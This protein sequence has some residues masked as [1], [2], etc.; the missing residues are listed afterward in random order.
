MRRMYNP[1]GDAVGL[2]SAH[3]S[4][5]G[6]CRSAW[7]TILLLLSSLAA[8][9]GTLYERRRDG[10]V[11][12]RDIDPNLSVSEIKAYRDAHPELSLTK[13]ME[14]LSAA[15]RRQETSRHSICMNPKEIA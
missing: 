13:A 6:S 4:S 9:G 8:L 15:K 14:E 3:C 10:P 12:T 11:D 5:P 1:S 7:A 2:V